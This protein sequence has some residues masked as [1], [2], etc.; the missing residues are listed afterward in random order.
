MKYTGNEVKNCYR[1]TSGGKLPKMAWRNVF[2]EKKRSILVFASVFMGSVTFLC[3][4]TFIDCLSADSYIAHYL[5]N[6]YVLYGSSDEGGA[7]QG[8]TMTDI[9][10]KMREIN[11]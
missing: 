4:N 5:H 10:E 9:A 6:D 7:D 2:R 1:T 11:S 8:V 3:V